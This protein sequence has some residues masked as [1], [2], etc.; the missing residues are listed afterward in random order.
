M[1]C[2]ICNSEN[3]PGAKFCDECGARLLSEQVAIEHMEEAF[4]SEKDLEERFGSFDL[5]D[6]EPA[7]AQDSE[8]EQEGECSRPQEWEDSA[9]EQIEEEPET[10]ADIAGETEVLQK[11]QADDTVDLRKLREERLA[12]EDD[13]LAG[14]DHSNADDITMVTPWDKGGTMKMQPVEAGPEKSRRFFADNDDTAPAK[15]KKP[16]LIGIALVIVA[17]LIAFG[18]WYFEL[19]GGYRIPDVVALNSSQASAV[20]TEKGFKVRVELVK[21]DDEEGIVLLTDPQPGSRMSTGGEVV[22]HVATPR[23]IPDLV[24]KT[25]DEAK[26]LIKAEGFTNV[27]YEKKKSNDPEG[28]VLEQSATPGA[29]QKSAYPL[30]VTVAEP[31]RVPK[32]VG[33]TKEEAI[34]LLHEEGYEVV[35]HRVYTETEPEGM[36]L[37]SNPA[38]EEKLNSGETVTISVA[39]SRKTE[40]IGATQGA[41]YS[42]ATFNVDGTPFEISS[43]NGISYEGGD[44]T[45][46]SVTARA[47]GYIMGHLIYLDPEDYTWLVNWTADNEIA[48]ISMG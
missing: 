28:T 46:V 25:E 34:T 20:L 16:L 22:L 48:S 35:I 3:R 5:A 23:V 15:T 9:E 12:K 29:K 10:V 40:L 44:T 38:A 17:A 11:G 39:V 4:G 13:V 26:A 8:S 14:L 42:G 32:V 2:P 31:Y 37:E 47:Y 19:W 24:G 21:S 7:D 18:T 33:L 41:V 43:V 36:V 1:I 6:Y 45:S 30:T 27:T